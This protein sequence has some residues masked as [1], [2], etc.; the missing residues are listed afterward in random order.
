LGFVAKASAA[1]AKASALRAAQ[2][3][4]DKSDRGGGF[5]PSPLPR[6]AAPPAPPAAAAAA[7]PVS[8]SPPLLLL[9]SLEAPPPPLPL[10]LLLPLPP[11]LPLLP[12]AV[13]AAAAAAAQA[14]LRQPVLQNTPGVPAGN[15]RR[16]T[17]PSSTHCTLLASPR[18]W[19]DHTNG[20]KSW[21]TRQPACQQ[22]GASGPR[23]H[24]NR[25][26]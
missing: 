14:R 2:S 9:L 18:A 25:N 1:S 23:N 7:P 6:A 13:A 12:P 3:A 19:A 5:A 8:P 16:R 11:L 15:P 17:M 22:T 24:R 10:L 26:S 21:A 4:A 20:E